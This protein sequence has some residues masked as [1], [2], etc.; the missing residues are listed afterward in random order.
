M[1]PIDHNYGSSERLKVA[2][3]GFQVSILADA[4][5]THFRMARPEREQHH[6]FNI[7]TFFFRP[8]AAGRTEITVKEKVVGSGVSTTLATMRQKGKELAEAHISYVDVPFLSKQLLSI[9]AVNSISR[10]EKQGADHLIPVEGG[11]C[12]EHAGFTR[13]QLRN[14][15]RADPSA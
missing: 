9:L 3:G 10:S 7:H 12:H 6:A 1:Q 14:R 2:H 15:L 11:Q 13:C 5:Q 4:V 8:A